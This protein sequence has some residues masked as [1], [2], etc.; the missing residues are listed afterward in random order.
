MASS[1]LSAVRVP[2]AGLE[3]GDARTLRPREKGRREPADLGRVLARGRGHAARIHRRRPER[4]QLGI[5]GVELLHALQQVVGR[6]ARRRRRKGDNLGR[7]TQRQGNGGR[8][9]HR[10]AVRAR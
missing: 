7:A 2:A 1:A 5:L 9:R 6:L 10:L 4:V 8:D 3:H